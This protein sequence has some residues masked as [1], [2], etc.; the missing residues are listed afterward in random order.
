MSKQQFEYVYY[1]KSKTVQVPSSGARPRDFHDPQGPPKHPGESP[2]VRPGN[3][4]GHFIVY[5]A[6]IAN[7]FV[8]HRKGGRRME[9]WRVP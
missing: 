6:E 7:D 9:D 4:T 8:Q 5:T 3:P 1:Q 2:E